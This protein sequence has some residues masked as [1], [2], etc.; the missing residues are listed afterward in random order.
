MRVEIVTVGREIL[1]GLTLNT[2]AH[3][4]AQALTPLG[5]R[6]HRMTTVDDDLEEIAA[7]VR[8]ARHRGT[9]LLVTTG[10]LG[11]TEDDLTLAGIARA[12]DLPLEP[13][14]EA[15]QMVKERYDAL[16]HEG[17]VPEPG[18]TPERRK[19]ALLPR[20][21]VPLPNRVGTA[22]A[23][24]LVHC[25]LVVF[26]LPGVPR[27]MQAF[28]DHEVLPWV[29]QHL[30]PKRQVRVLR[31]RTG[32]ADESVIERRLRPLRRRFPQAYFKSKPELFDRR[33]NIPLEITL[34]AE[35][36]EELQTLKT[37]VLQ[38]LKE[39]FHDLEPLEG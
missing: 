30:A 4:L 2:N 19:M 28:L 38:A 39:V 35:T 8:E 32:L 6:P 27:E 16:Y 26:A 20:G 29:R 31:V 1:A 3:V 15:L 22:P 11:P 7:A 10:G 5:L 13:H 24:R 9:R 23:V 21:S 18:L 12:L 33:T 14:P 25:G 17:K 34:S 37:R 36:E